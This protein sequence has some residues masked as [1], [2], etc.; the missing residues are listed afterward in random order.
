MA[1]RST[2]GKRLTNPEKRGSNQELP[3]HGRD[4]AVFDL[5]PDDT[6]CSLPQPTRRNVL[7]QD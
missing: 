6:G 3:D 5:G 2:H 4:E 1:R 7:N